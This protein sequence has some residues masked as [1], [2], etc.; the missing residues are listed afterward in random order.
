[1]SFEH[2]F[3][4]WKKDPTYRV[5]FLRG[6]CVV[7]V[8]SPQIGFCYQTD[9]DGNREIELC[10]EP[11][12]RETAWKTDRYLTCDPLENLDTIEK[13]ARKTLKITLPDVSE[14]VPGKEYPLDF[15]RQLPEGTTPAEI[16]LVVS[17]GEIRQ[18]IENQNSAPTIDGKY[19][20][21]FG[22]PNR[23]TIRIYHLDKSGN[24]L[25]WG[26]TEVEVN[27]ADS[28]QD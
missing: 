6:N 12:P 13:T 2:K 11:A 8:L 5:T 9:A 10:K 28:S 20:V 4:M 7:N 22:Q 21:L 23:Q 19:T 3:G 27:T 15:S 25:A 17:R 14:F 26:K 16:R 1:M 24:C 18:I